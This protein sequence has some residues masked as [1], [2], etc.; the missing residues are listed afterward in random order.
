MSKYRF[1]AIESGYEVFYRGKSLGR[2][3]PMKESTGRH[4]FYLG[5]DTR[6]KPRTYRGKSQ[7]AEALH[8]IQRLV[9]NMNAKQW[10]PEMLIIQAWDERPR[11]SQQW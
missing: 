3:L 8:A 7:A 5:D 4:C 9:Q 10:S 6:K 1:D 2:I 11:A